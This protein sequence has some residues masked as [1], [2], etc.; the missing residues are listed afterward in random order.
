MSLSRAHTPGVASS[1]H[2]AA[3]TEEEQQGE[4]DQRPPGKHTQQHQQQ[5]IVLCLVRGH[6]HILRKKTIGQDPGTTT[7]SQVLE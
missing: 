5:H 2:A 1:T 4:Q 3:V 7:L 6:R